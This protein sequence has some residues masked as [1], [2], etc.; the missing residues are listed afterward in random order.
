MY[1]NEYCLYTLYSVYIQYSY[2]PV[3][4]CLGVK[5]LDVSVRFFSAPR[6]SGT[7]PG[8]TFR[9]AMRPWEIPKALPPSPVPIRTR[10]RPRRRDR[11]QQLIDAH[12][13]DP[14]FLVVLLRQSPRVAE[15]LA[16]ALRDKAAEDEA[17]A[18]LVVRSCVALTPAGP[19]KRNASGLTK[20]KG[21][22]RPCVTP[23]SLWSA[24]EECS[25]VPAKA[26][27]MEATEAE[28]L[29]YPLPLVLTT[30]VS[31][32]LKLREKLLFQASNRQARQLK[33]LVSAWEPL[34]LDATDCSYIL[35]C[36]RRVDP[37]G[38]L[39]PRF[40]PSPAC[41]AWAEVTEVRVEMMEPDHPPGESSGMPRFHRCSAMSSM[42]LDPIDELARRLSM[43]WFSGAS[44][45]YLS[46]I[47]STRMD[48]L[49]LDFRLKAFRNFPCLRVRHEGLDLSRYLLHACK[50]PVPLP[51]IANA[52]AMMQE[53]FPRAAELRLLLQWPEEITE[54]E[55]LFLQEHTLMLKAGNS[56][57]SLHRLWHVITEEEVRE[58]YGRLHAQL[59]HG[60]DPHSVQP[61]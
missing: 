31:S 47:D 42:I 49:F 29:L 35:R 32:F 21:R 10:A 26:A 22:R 51:S 15:V 54:P 33:E 48:A 38:S 53:R 25:E 41:P 39:E 5:Q 17:F 3:Y 9:A 4:V 37:R 30:Q 27:K 6:R 40:Y 61:K 60:F 52:H 50:A 1:I 16:E 46:N 18:D 7:L 14:Q 43:G 23:R 11:A 19:Q 57:R 58:Q 24:F 45:L 13:N 2:M 59:C 44:H 12:L 36:L 55:A 20:V 34:V 28:S 56:F 8:T